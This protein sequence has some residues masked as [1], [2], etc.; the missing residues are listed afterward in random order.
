MQTTPI[1]TRANQTSI[2]RA[3][4]SISALLTSLTPAQMSNFTQQLRTA[5]TATT[6]VTTATS[7]LQPD[8]YGLVTLASS[9]P[10]RRDKRAARAKIKEAR[11]E[12]SKLRPLNAFMAFR[13][14]FLQSRVKGYSADSINSILLITASWLDAE[15][16]VR[17]RP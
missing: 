15:G 17:S 7:T 2:E 12:R 1:A 10:V 11:A 3:P 13:C 4:F 8:Q 5:A 14:K 16:E 9:S 6:R